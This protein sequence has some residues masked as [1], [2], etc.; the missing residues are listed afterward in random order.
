MARSHRVTLTIAGV[1]VTT[2]DEIAITHDLFSPA[3]AYTVTLWREADA[4]RWNEVRRACRIFAPVIVEIDGAVQLRGTLE[5][6]KVGGARSGAP[7]TLSGRSLAGPAMV[8]HV[9]PRI[10]LRGVTL[11]E[12]LTRIFAPL[13]IAVTVGVSAEDARATMAGA[14][15]GPVRT[16]TRRAHH[17][18]DRFRLKP[19]QTVWQAAE[20][21]CR[22]HGYLLYAAPTAD[23][24]GL[25][26]DRPAYDAPVQYAL[27]RTKVRVDAS[28]EATWTGN[29][30]EGFRDLNGTDAQTM[31]T[32]FGHSGLDAPQDARHR[33][34][35][36]NDRLLFHPLV[37]DVIVERPHYIRDPRARTPQIAEQRARRE[38]ALTMADFDTY[39]A[40]VQGFAQGS[41]AR[42][43]AIN[44]MV[45]VVDELALLEDDWLVTSATFTR[46]RENGHT[47]RLRLVPKGSIVIDPDPE[48]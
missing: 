17:K 18:V 46:S 7:L 31:T 25:V 13:G 39:N 14:R 9:D 22:R 15:P 32:V 8:A 47:T 2:W 43:W 5:R 33:G 27:S 36:S 21:L 6:L 4:T 10:S 40:T 11:H 42:V 3:G 34:Q 29:V 26:I 48:V 20:M 19:G 1:P 30:L 41:P 44:S 35:V 28:G 38:N 12:A 16:G 23:G 24:L 37:S 45:H